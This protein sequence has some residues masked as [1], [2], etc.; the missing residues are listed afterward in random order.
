MVSAVTKRQTWTTLR[1]WPWRRA[2]PMACN[3]CP[4][5]LSCVDASMGCKNTTWLAAVRFVPDA[6]CASESKRTNFDDV[7]F[8]CQSLMMCPR[9]LGPPTSCTV[10]MPNSKSAFAIFLLSSSNW[11]KRITF[12]VGSA[13]RNS[14][15]FF[16]TAASFV[17]Y[18]RS[19]SSSGGG[20]AEGAAEDEDEDP[21]EISVPGFSSSKETGRTSLRFRALLQRLHFLNFSTVAFKQSMQKV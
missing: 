5:A 3:S 10:G 7:K 20:G 9:W 19:L 6:D 2:R 16:D 15:N 17:P 18:F 11:T 8:S 13:T 4:I 1:L 21:V 14:R 12:A